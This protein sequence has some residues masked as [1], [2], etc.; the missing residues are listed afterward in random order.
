ME[1]RI[2]SLHWN[3]H[4]K[5]GTNLQIFRSLLSTSWV[6]KKFV[7]MG[8]AKEGALLAPDSKK[9]IEF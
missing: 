2:K 8:D 9:P 6:T 7:D 3:K 4:F 1:P 5:I